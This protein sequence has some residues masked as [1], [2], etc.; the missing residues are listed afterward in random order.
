VSCHDLIILF[1]VN[2]VPPLLNSSCVQFGGVNI[3]VNVVLNVEL[4]VD[5]YLWLTLGISCMLLQSLT[6]I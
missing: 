6:N 4:Y 5:C 1:I 2:I 3:C